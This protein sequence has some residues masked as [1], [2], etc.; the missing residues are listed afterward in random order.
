M[1]ST[2]LSIWRV[3]KR[4]MHAIGRFQTILIV[5]SFYLIVLSP[6]GSIMQLFGFD[7]LE[8]SRRSQGRASNWK[9]IDDK[10]PTINSL[11][12]QS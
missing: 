8:K 11:K 4:S 6:I 1:K 3:V 10:A 9:D 5:T 12:R 2:A 7:P